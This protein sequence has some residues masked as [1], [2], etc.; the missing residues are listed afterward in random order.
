[1]DLVNEA[2]SPERALA[3]SYAP[4]EGWAALTALFALDD[5]LRR[6]TRVARDPTVGLM[7]LTW[8]ADALVSL[9]TA[10]PPAEP[11]LTSLA[12]EV[13]PHGVTGAAM[14]GMVDGWERLLAGD[15]LDHDAFAAERGGRL[16][17]LAATVLAA[18]DA[19]VER[20]GEGWALI[21][22]AQGWS[23]YAAGREMGAG[24][25]N[26]MYRSSWPRPLR[27]LGAQG[28]SALADARGEPAGSPRRVGRLLWHR[29]TGR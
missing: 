23:E 29:L 17:A 9:D 20:M 2:V 1:M 15:P 19:R 4:A 13:L 21:D 6:I 10:P 8:W 12:R 5:R 11:L 28:L 27:P 24:R 26:T 22:L 3:L 18:T 14:A 25:L 16:F 7:R